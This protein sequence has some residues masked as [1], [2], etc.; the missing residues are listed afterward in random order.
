MEEKTIYKMRREDNKSKE[1]QNTES[2][3]SKES[4]GLRWYLET[5]KIIRERTHREVSDEGI[6]AAFK[7]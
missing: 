5:F 1:M 6:N 7:C 4:H 3:C 2:F